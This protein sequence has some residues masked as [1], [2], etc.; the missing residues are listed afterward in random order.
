MSP[1]C[2]IISSPGKVGH[3]RQ[4]QAIA[5]R[6]GA[7]VETV[8]ACAARSPGAGILASDL[9]LAA[10][11]Q[12]IAPA[13]A[14]V[15]ARSGARPLVCVL[16]PVTWRPGRFDLLWA[17]LHDR[18]RWRVLGPVRLVETLTAPCAVDRHTMAR[19]A[20]ELAAREA[21]GPPPRIGVLVGGPSAA[22]RFGRPEAGDLAAR[23]AAFADAH[24]ATMLVST[25]R[26]T[27]PQA[28][29]LIRERLGGGH[30]VLD[31]AAPGAHE[32]SAAYAAILG[33]ADAFI[34]TS[35]SVAMMSEA[36]AT[37]K[38]I[39]GWRLPGG[40]AKFERFYR[41]LEAHGALRWF[42]GSLGRWHY[43]PLDA[44]ATIADAL[45]PAL[46]LARGGSGRI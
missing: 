17:P 22:H 42:D 39:H 21:I 4:A 7:T 40:K 20:D 3:A 1:R 32:P 28:A 5:A 36:A 11:R 23:L 43:P 8:C 25:S 19:A 24:D 29:V 38:P 13:R 44:A 26:R 34:V 45:R 9:V 6:L 14:I 31:A 46:G 35:D 15:D 2:T 33:L 16:Q 18:A 12:S 27:P 37:G 10:G 30:F 41:G